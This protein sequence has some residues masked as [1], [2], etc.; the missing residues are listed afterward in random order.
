MT[1]I[2]TTAVLI[3]TGLNKAF[4][5]K[6]V[7]QLQGKQTIMFMAKK[8]TVGGRPTNRKRIFLEVQIIMLKACSFW[9]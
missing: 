4:S 5:A 8:S 9:M 1:N 6:N 2:L 7:W 3:I